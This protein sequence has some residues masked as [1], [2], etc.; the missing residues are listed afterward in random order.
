ME[1]C[2]FDPSKFSTARV[3]FVVLRGMLHVVQYIGEVCRYLVAQPPKETD[4]QHHVRL[5][6]GN[7]LRK[8]VWTEFQR[9]FKVPLIGELYGATESNSSII[10]CDGKPGAIGFIPQS[11]KGIYPIYLIKMDP[12]TEEPVRDPDSGLCIECEPNEP[13]QLIG[14]IN[15]RNPSRFY[16]GYVNKEASDKKILRNV[17]RPGDTW[18][19]SGDLLYRD[20]LGYLYFSDRLGDTFRWRG[21][22]V[23]TS[24][25]EAVMLRAFP[26]MVVSVYGVSVPGNEGKAGMAAIVVNFN[27]LLPDEEQ[28]MVQKILQEVT[29]HLPVYA[30]PLFLRLCERIEMTST[31]KMRKVE[32]V[33]AGFDPSVEGDH[34]Y[35]LNSKSNAYCR[36]DKETFD[37]LQQGAIR[38]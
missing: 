31:F 25:V 19:A 7:G 32:L 11:I 17:F 35:W 36:L 6:F 18:F 14:R 21:E 37:Q 30:R 4:T 29:N 12:I 8:E 23:S 13:G 5:A 27:E 24:E 26:D 10:N 34:V 16:D 20:E 33:K 3:L 22:N 1:I 38:L 2:S 28:S 15:N 9:R